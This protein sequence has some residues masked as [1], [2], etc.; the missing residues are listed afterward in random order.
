MIIFSEKLMIKYFNLKAPLIFSKARILWENIRQERLF[1]QFTPKLEVIAVTF[2]PI[3]LTCASL[4]HGKFTNDHTA[5]LEQFPYMGTVLSNFIQNLKEQLTED[6]RENYIHFTEWRI[7]HEEK[8]ASLRSKALLNYLIGDISMER[9]GRYKMFPNSDKIQ[10]EVESLGKF[11]K[12]A[13]II[14]EEYGTLSVKDAYL[15]L[16]RS[17]NKGWTLTW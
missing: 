6:Q 7:Y 15:H 3:Y 1:I 17:F 5:Y 9:T 16:M 8:G 4:Y 10:K 14:S 12:Y 2:W 13:K 11:H